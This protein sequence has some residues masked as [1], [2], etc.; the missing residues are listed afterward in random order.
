MNR[1]E[2]IERRTPMMEAKASGA[3]ENARIPSM[4]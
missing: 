1:N 4:E 3:V 2:I